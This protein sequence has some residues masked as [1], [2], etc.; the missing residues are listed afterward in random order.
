MLRKIFSA[1]EALKKW[2]NSMKVQITLLKTV[3]LSC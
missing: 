2:C 1:T 3:H